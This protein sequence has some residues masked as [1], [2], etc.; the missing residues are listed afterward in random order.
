MIARVVSFVQR[1]IRLVIQDRHGDPQCHQRTIVDVVAA[2]VRTVANTLNRI[3]SW[4][5]GKIAS[6]VSRRCAPCS[7]HR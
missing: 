4:L 6:A 2:G 1:A 5:I 3:K 7:T